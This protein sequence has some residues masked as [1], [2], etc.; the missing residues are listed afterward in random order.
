MIKKVFKIIKDFIKE[1]YKFLISLIIIATILVFPLPYYVIVGGG[2]TD[3]TKRVKVENEYQSIGSFNFTF[4]KELNGTTVSYLYGKLLNKEII[5]SN[6]VKLDNESTKDYQLREKIAM[7]E[8]YDNA[9]YS[10][11]KL[12][13][14]E[15]DEISSN[16]K[17][18]YILKE[19]DTTLKVGDEILKIN[20]TTIS[21]TEEYQEEFSK[22]KVG[23]SLNILV[24]RD[25]KEILCYAKV[26][27][28]AGRSVVGL[29]TYVDRKYETAPKVSFNMKKKESGPS[30]GL[31]LALTIYNK[32]VEEDITKG[33]KIAGTGTIDINGNI[34]EIGGIKYK[35]EGA[36]KKK[37]DIFIAPSGKNYQ[38]VVELV[39]KN[40]YNIKVI[41]AKTLS[42]VVNDL[43]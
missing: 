34:G 29:Y 2:V 15:I 21:N 22:Y 23:D 32:L 30:G 43:S 20:D 4:V 17:I 33:Y 19:A 26:I 5:K 12:A 1:E 36:V 14:K 28:Y 41:E 39:Q 10:A 24:K 18:L 42:Q 37:V 16:I 35:L 9:I 27:D 13:G 25:G 7:M 11:Y 8:S 40:N 31:M 6:S 3:I 38:E